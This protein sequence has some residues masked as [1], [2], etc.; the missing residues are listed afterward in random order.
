MLRFLNN[1]ILT[2]STEAFYPKYANFQIVRWARKPRFLPTAKTKLFRVSQRPVIPEEDREEL[3]RLYNIYRTE[4]KSLKN[5]FVEKYSAENLEKFDI[6]QHNK[7]IREDFIACNKI[8]DEWNQQIKLQREER[9]TNE[10]EENIELAMQRRDERMQRLVGK[11]EEIENI[12]SREKEA[13]ETFIDRTHIEDTIEYAINN[14]V[15]YNFAI[16][17][18]GNKMYGREPIEN[19]KLPI[20]Q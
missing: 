11:L 5:F 7:G 10:L 9:F 19:D 20:K 8:N 15:D 16:D 6:E 17:V 18:D 1:N 13:S 2:L 14:P 4:I 3:K 12:V